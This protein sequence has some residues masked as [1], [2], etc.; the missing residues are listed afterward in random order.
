ML[1][2]KK[3]TYAAS[4]GAARRPGLRVGRR[5]IM[6]A[7]AASSSTMARMPAPGGNRAC[8]EAYLGLRLKPKP[9]TSCRKLEPDVSPD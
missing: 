8:K 1:T 5:A 7:S 3:S 6:P 4:T 2:W 9:T